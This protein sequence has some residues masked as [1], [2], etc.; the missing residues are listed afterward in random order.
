VF[1]F[2]FFPLICNRNIIKSAKCNQGTQKVYKRN[3]YLEREERTRKSLKLISK[4]V[5]T[6][7]KFRYKENLKK[8]DLS[9]SNVLSLSLKFCSFTYLQRHHKRQEATIFHKTTLL[10]RRDFIIG[11]FF[12]FAFYSYVTYFHTLGYVTFFWALCYF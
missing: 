5:K 4:G 1:F 9:S 6:T 12:Y 3:A 8:N 7:L 10:R 2:F 11:T